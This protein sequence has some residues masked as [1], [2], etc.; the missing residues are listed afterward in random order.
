M[1][2]SGKC[3]QKGEDSE[4]TQRHVMNATEGTRLFCGSLGISDY[5][6]R[7]GKCDGSRPICKR[8]DSAGREVRCHHLSL[9]AASLPTSVKC[10]WVKTDSRLH[11]GAQLLE[12][13][14]K[15]A[16]NLRKLLVEYYR[17][18]IHLETQL[19]QCPQNL[20]S[21][22]NFRASR[23]I[24]PVDLV[25]SSIHLENMDLEFALMDEEIAEE[26]DESDDP[27]KE[28][29]LPTQRLMV[30]IEHFFL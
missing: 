10:T 6:N 22:N 19:D 26:S 16:A 30:H 15:L 7:K 13:N 27:T 25:G 1:N 11:K 17:Y 18:A 23:P 29:R 4:P 14:R 9:S 20:H 2:H 8:C 21:R 28:I 5:S 3:R 12:S 24:D